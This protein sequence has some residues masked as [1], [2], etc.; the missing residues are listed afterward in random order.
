MIR[1]PVVAGHFY[2]AGKDALRRAVAGLRPQTPA[3]VTV[4]A[5]G[6]VSPHAGYPYSGPVAAAVRA[7]VAPRQTYIIMGPNHTGLG[8]P[9]GLSTATAWTTPL[10]D[11]PV[12]TALAEAIAA[13]SRH[14]RYDDLCHAQEHSVEVQLPFLQ[15]TQEGFRFVPLVLADAPLDTYR[16]IGIELAA[17]VRKCGV[18][19]DVM[20]I[21]SSDM[22]HYE[23]EAAAVKKDRMAIDAV[24]ALDEARLMGAITRH[25]I[26]M[27]GYAPVCAMLAAARSLGATGARLIRYATSGEATGDHSSVVGYA[28]IAIT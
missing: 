10:G 1:K 27:C 8:L 19:K 6:I 17:A 20:I 9:F 24:L 13:D 5:I 3:D 12:D 11:V 7:A 18:E 14:I 16:E 22:T 25:G 15:S 28:G 21:A 23:P 4:N 26:S 2:P